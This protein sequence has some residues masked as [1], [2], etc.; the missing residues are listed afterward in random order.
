MKQA[1]NK[2]LICWML[3]IIVSTVFAKLPHFPT[4]FLSWLNSSLYF[5][6][7]ILSLFISLKD[8]YL[9]EIFISFSV[10]FF[11][12]SFSFFTLFVGDKYLLGN[13]FWLY[14]LFAYRKIAMA[15]LF[16]FSI[17]CLVFR[18][19]LP[20]W[21]RLKL[22][23]LS[24]LLTLSLVIYHF[25]PFLLNQKAIFTM[26]I[27]GVYTRILPVHLLPFLSLFVYGY[28]L[29]SYDRPNGAFLNPFAMGLFISSSLDIIDVLARIKFLNIYGID[30]YFLTACL[31]AMVVTLALRLAALYSEEYLLKERFIFDPAFAAATP[32]IVRDVKIVDLL[33]LVKPTLDSRYFLINS[34]LS[35]AFIGLS[36]LAKSP[37]VTIKMALIVFWIALFWHLFNQLFDRRLKYGQVLNFRSIK[38]SSQE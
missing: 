4:C 23:L 19:A 27:S 14:Y 10:A 38:K 18:Y 32:V 5:L 3:F 8:R 16:S 28:V 7:G 36:A 33:K 26:G 20:I 6:L 9:K 29:F 13:N 35:L 25:W 34:V 22:C 37:V 17:L 2:I 11:F 12:V 30:Q 24:A 15:S 31:L 21:S 1:A